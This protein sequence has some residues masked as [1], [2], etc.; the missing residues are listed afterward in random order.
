MEKPTS[1]FRVGIYARISEDRYGDQTA[2]ARQLEDC[3]AFVERKGWVLVDTFEDV[4]ISAYN[5]RAKRPEF[6]RMLVA[7]KAGEMDGIVVWKL[8]RLTR[9]QRDL[10]RVIE[11]CEPHKAFIASVMEPIDTR[12]I[13]GQ[14]IAELLVAQARMESAN[15][16]TRQQ[17]KAAEMA[18]LGLPSVG[19]YRHFGYNLH[20]TEVV[21]E[22][23]KLIRAGVEHILA[24]GSIRSLCFEWQTSGV[25][26]PTGRPWQPSPLRRMLE[27]PV[28]SAQR[29][30]KG[31]L[32]AGNWQP[33]VSP[34]TTSA[35]R[36]VLRGSSRRTS[37]GPTRKRLLSGFLRCG[38]CGERMVGR[39]RVDGTP[40]YVCSR[41][42][43]KPNCGGIAILTEPVDALVLEMLV[44]AL[45]TAQLAA[46]FQGRTDGNDELGDLIRQD[47][48]AMETL[49]ADFYVEKLISREE[50]LTA[51]RQLS[52][53][54]EQ[55]RD[56][57]AR[58]TGSG[59]LQGL[60]GR[61]ADLK[62]RWQD[63]TLDRKRSILAAVFDHIKVHRAVKGRRAFDAKRIEPVWRI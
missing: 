22:E 32:S 53:R 19:G 3:R 8:D 48:I 37:P 50:F 55:N 7:I 27:S 34:E 12:D 29:E 1:P 24:G 26:T 6:E 23:A 44:A 28:L 39:P 35:V 25:H 45:D 38:L 57:L 10:V 4:D 51:R 13:H 11:A 63:E 18:K 30:H 54:L 58:R 15:T 56:R 61:G 59:A 49:A 14:F 2:T 31:V 36:S 16:S 52:E 46:A 33:I 62:Q 9:Q 21:E 41:A 20:R 47:E 42:P 5:K 17:R 43:G 60:I 40:R